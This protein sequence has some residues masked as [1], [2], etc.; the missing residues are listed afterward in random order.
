MKKAR[1]FF[2][3]SIC[4]GMFF[5]STTIFAVLLAFNFYQEVDYR[6]WYLIFLVALSIACKI[7]IEY[8]ID[9]SNNEKS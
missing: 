6:F 4:E 3:K 7:W 2:W 1:L 9:K 5:L 8:L